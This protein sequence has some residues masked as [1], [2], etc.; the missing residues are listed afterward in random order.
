MALRDTDDQLEL[1]GPHKSHPS[2]APR[3]ENANV[4]VFHMGDVS[5]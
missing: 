4:I 1:Y 3:R 2:E 5:W